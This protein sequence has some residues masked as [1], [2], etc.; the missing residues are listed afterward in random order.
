VH[1]KAKP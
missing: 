1:L